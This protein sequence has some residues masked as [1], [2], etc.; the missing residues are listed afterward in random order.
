MIPQLFSGGPVHP[1]LTCTPSCCTLWLLLCFSRGSLFG[2][3]CASSF[4][5]PLR[6]LGSRS[7]NSFSPFFRRRVG[8]CTAVV[9][10]C[11][12]Y[13]FVP[14]VSSATG[15]SPLVGLRLAV[16]GTLLG[17]RSVLRDDAAA[18]PFAVSL[19]TPFSSAGFHL[20]QTH[21]ALVWPFSA[22]RLTLCVYVFK[23]FP[24]LAH[25]L[26]SPGRGGPH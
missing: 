12:S 2:C 10:Y 6:C 15:P 13:R 23:P 24:S 14:F 5:L 26:S 18:L 4:C 16:A 8:P 20:S 3:R 21:R 25:S 19:H 9:R 1:S 22:S 11:W 7:L 17:A